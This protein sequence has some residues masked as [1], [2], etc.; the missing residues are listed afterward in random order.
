[1]LSEKSRSAPLVS[2]GWMVEGDD[3][4]RIMSYT[5]MG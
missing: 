2:N 1:M 4:L 5:R 3:M